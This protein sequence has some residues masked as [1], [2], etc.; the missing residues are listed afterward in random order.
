MGAVSV[1]HVEDTISQKTS[2][3]SGS[4][5]HSANQLQRL[6]LA[7]G[8]GLALQIHWSGLCTSHSHILATTSICC[9]NRVSLSG[10]K[11]TLTYLGIEE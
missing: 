4:Y 2:W 3:S 5:N 8:V 7:L 6:S 10:V 1:S 9:T 11:G